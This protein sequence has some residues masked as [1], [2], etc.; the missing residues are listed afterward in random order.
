M[1]INIKMLY[2]RIMLLFPIATLFQVYF[3]GINKVLFAILLVLQL[4]LLLKNRCFLNWVLIVL[5]LLLFGYDLYITDGNL[6]NSNELFYYPFA[7]IFLIYSSFTLDDV[8][9]YFINDQRYIK[10]IIILWSLIVF[11]SVFVS[12]SWTSSWG[13]ARYFGSFCQS[14]WRLAPTAVFIGCLSIAYMN[15]L[16]KKKYF[17][18][19]IIPMFCFLM[20]GSRTYLIVGVLMFLLGWYYFS[21]TKRGF[22]ISLIPL[23]LFL[24]LMIGHS[25]MIDKFNAVSYSNNSY[26]DFWGTLTSGRSIFW[27]ADLVA[28]SNL[29]FINKLLGNGLNFVYI[30]NYNAIDGLIWAHNDFIQCLLSHGLV[31]LSLYCIAIYKVIKNITFKQND[32][33]PVLLAIFIWLV[34]AFFNMFYTYFCSILSFIFVITAVKYA[35]KRK[36]ERL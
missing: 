33:I 30:V 19:L 2:Y 21:K 24:L 15:I 16:K 36:D 35:N 27:E 10:F 31:G 8:Y 7:I 12:S 34:N 20:G 11:I 28:F 22:Y 3:N 26:F 13:G 4:L 6:Y 23:F 9:D 29:N 25:S 1:R 32:N 5:M 18:F 17:Y 14:I